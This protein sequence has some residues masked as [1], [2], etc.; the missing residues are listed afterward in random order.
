[1]L[2]PL[3]WPA[4][5]GEAEIDLLVEKDGGDKDE[6]ARE[7][8]DEDEDVLLEGVGGEEAEEETKT[9]E[10]GED[11]SVTEGRQEAVD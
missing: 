8:V 11:E 3:R 1:M 5:D 7:A 2:L 9:K 4:A 6:E 10:T